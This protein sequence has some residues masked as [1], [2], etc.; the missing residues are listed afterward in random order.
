MC[1]SW[2]VK[3]TPGSEVIESPTLKT[4]KEVHIWMFNCSSLIMKATFSVH[5]CPLTMSTLP[6]KLRKY[7]HRG[8]KWIWFVN[9][10]AMEILLLWKVPEIQEKS[11]VTPLHLNFPTFCMAFVLIHQLPLQPTIKYNFQPLLVLSEA[12]PGTMRQCVSYSKWE[13]DNFES[14]VSSIVSQHFASRH[15]VL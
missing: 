15:P 9:L 6:S 14:C 13:R 4:P 8:S 10:P 12:V 3:E 11:P 5:V 1:N 7:L 2:S